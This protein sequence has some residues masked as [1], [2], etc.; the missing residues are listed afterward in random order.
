MGNSLSLL[1]LGALILASGWRLLVTVSMASIAGGGLV[2]WFIGQSGTN[3]IGA[4][5]VVFGYLT[6]L[7]ASGFYRP[8]P[9]SILITLFIIVFYGGSLLG[10]L[11]TDSMRTA[12]VS[13]EGHLGGALGGFFTARNRR[14]AA[15]ITRR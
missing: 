5:S 7:L 12:G 8:S 2:V 15:R 6:F 4:S 10:M 11:P 3:H 1:I 14:R 9:V 13:W